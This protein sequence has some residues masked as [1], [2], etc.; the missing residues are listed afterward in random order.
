[1]SHTFDFVGLNT[2]ISEASKPLSKVSPELARMAGEEAATNGTTP[3]NCH[4]SYFATEA[5]ESEWYRGYREGK[6]HG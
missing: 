1:M 5:L 4:Y 2:V 6:K 3:R